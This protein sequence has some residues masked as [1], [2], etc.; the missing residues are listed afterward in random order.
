MTQIELYNH[1]KTIGLPLSYSYFNQEVEPPYLLYLFSY[2]DDLIADDKNYYSISNFQIE[3]Y[4][5]KKDLASEKLVEDK[6]KSIEL[7][8]KKMET[9]I[10][11][12]KVFQ[13]LY[14]VQI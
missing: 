7:P 1:L 14:E 12:E 4:T 11:D 8:Y 5:N 13:I 10:S 6:L 2:S 3:L 9:Y